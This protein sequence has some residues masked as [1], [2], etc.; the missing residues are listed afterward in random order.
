MLNKVHIAEAYYAAIQEGRKNDIPSFYHPNV[1][2][3]TPLGASEGS[4][5][6]AQAASGFSDALKEMVFRAKVGQGD[7]VML[8]CDVTFKGS[9]EPLKTAVLLDFEGD[10]IRRIECFYD[11]S[12]VAEAER[13]QIFD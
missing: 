13:K 8:A 11:G 4:K 5:A 12:Q 6:V 7:K 2:F 3:M 9:H 1:S 10:K